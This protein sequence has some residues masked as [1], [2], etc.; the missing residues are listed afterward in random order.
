MTEQPNIPQT[1]QPAD[2][3]EAAEV[4]P[5]TGRGVLVGSL[6][7]LALIPSCIFLVVTL[8]WGPTD[9]WARAIAVAFVGSCLAA[10]WLARRPKRTIWG[11]IGSATAVVLAFLISTLLVC[12]LIWPARIPPKPDCLTNLQSI[13]VRLSEYQIAHGRMPAQLSDLD[14]NRFPP[15]AS[16][17]P[18]DRA[19]QSG[20]SSYFYFLNTSRSQNA[21][22][23]CEIQPLHNGKRGVLHYWGWTELLDDDQ[24]QKALARPEN[25]AF[26]AALRAFEATGATHVLLDLPS[27]ATRPSQ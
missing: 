17:C 20:Y 22:V 27:S 3:P 5:S 6:V 11:K 12:S 15:V 13:G 18:R 23:L 25:A 1:P 9:W 19:C 21:V 16:R 4:W 7:L 2:S 10:I 24:F 8:A 14:A 26:A